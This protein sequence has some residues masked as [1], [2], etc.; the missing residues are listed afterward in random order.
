MRAR[1]FTLMEVLIAL[2]ITSI[3]GGLVWGSFNAGFK[4]KEVIESEAD[5]YREL[6]TGMSRIT[7]ELS[8]AFISENYDHTRFRDN[9][10][11][12]TFFSGERDRLSFSMFGHQRLLQ[13][14][15]ES[16]QSAVY[17]K[18]DRD[19]EEKSKSSL[20][21]CERP[22]LAE[23][24]DRCEKWETLISGVKKVEFKYW[25]NQRKEWID[26][27]DTRRNDR[28]FQL[29]DRVRIELTAKNELGKDQ[30]YVTQGRVNMV[31]VLRQ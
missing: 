30:K 22:V 13:D 10:D 24:M 21:R 11:R 28:P 17:Y 20:L 2:A 25:D 15:K 19:P 12:P 26:T 14:A 29:P 4:A 18:V 31:A 27:W 6:R 23:N 5:I 9:Q 3:I 8:M 1:G 7:R 16:D